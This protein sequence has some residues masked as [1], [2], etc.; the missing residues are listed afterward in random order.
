MS[1]STSGVETPRPAERLVLMNPGPV[2]THPE[3]RKALSG[4]DLCHREQEFS[5]LMMEVRSKVVEITGGTAEYRSVVLTGSGTSAVEAIIASAVPEAGKL[6]VLDN[7]HYGHRM[8]TIARAY[9][10]PTISLSFGWCGEI[11]L[12]RVESMLAHDSGITHVAVVHHETST[13]ML[14]DI[15]EVARIASK[16]SAET[17]IDAVSSVGAEEIVL[18]TDKAI[19]LAGSSNKCLEGM[20]GLSFVIASQESLESLSTRKQRSFSLD[21]NRHYRAQEKLKT[22]A[23]TPSIP[24]FYAFNTALDLAIAEGVKGRFNRYE[25]LAIILRTGL[26]SL[27]LE[28][29]IPEG[30]RAVSLTAVKIPVGCTYQ[31]LHTT[32]RVAGFVI[33][34]AQEQLELD[35]FRLSTMGQMDEHD[36][37]KFL[38]VLRQYILR[39]EHS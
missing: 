32:L 23:F 2:M 14:N 22:P 4:P 30:Q 28:I 37:R 27:G 9:N 26:R 13:G 8:F 10:I 24:A 33:Y 12:A 17:I 5:N 1:L 21:L 6:L 29:L 3:V 38:E 11:D 39:G 20:P 19:W 18:T 36:I 15:R 31:A 35:Y 7:G 34:A 25:N 16:Y